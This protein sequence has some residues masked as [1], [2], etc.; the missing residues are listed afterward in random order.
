VNEQ[1]GIGVSRRD[2][3]FDLIEWHDDVARGRLVQT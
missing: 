3:C 1:S 2:E